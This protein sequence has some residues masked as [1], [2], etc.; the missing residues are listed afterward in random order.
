MTPLGERASD[1]SPEAL[2]FSYGGRPPYYFQSDEARHISEEGLHVRDWRH[3]K[4]NVVCRLQGL[5]F[6]N[7]P[8]EIFK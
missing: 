8:Q 2:N 4:A 7:A 6:G 5:P 3:V 1:S